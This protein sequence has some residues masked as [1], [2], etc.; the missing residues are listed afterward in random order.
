[1]SIFFKYII[2]FREYGLY[3]YLVKLNHCLLDICVFCQAAGPVTPHTIV[4]LPNN[5]GMQLLLCYDST[6]WSTVKLYLCTSK[7]VCYSGRI[8]Q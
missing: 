5:S 2:L 6:F 3:I 7:K 8:L 4:I 1:M